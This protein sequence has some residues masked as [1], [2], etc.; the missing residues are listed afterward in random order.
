MTDALDYLLRV[1]PE[2]M[3]PYFKFLKEGGRR[4][5]PKTRALISMITKVAT[6]TE[7]G[8]RQYLPRALR[9]GATADE[10]LDALLAAFP[11]LGL[12]KIVW[13]VDILLEMDIP[14]FQPDLLGAEPRW[15]DVGP[16]NSIRK[17]K[18]AHRSCDGRSV[19]IYGTGDEIRVYDT[20]CPHQ[21]TNIPQLALQGTKLTCP[22]HHWAFDI[23]TGE[24]IEIGD[25]PLTCFENKVEKG[26][27]LAYW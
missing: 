16:V 6:Q 11:V 4:L 15:H 3:K 24:C 25:R 19:F 14:E 13:A 8:F 20:R 23:T 10:V 9:A 5:D 27:L 2:A 7:S 17:G 21:V 1:R 18:V 12:A 26:R 22:K